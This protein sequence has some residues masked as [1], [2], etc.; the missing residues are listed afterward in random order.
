MTKAEAIIEQ[1]NRLPEPHRTQALNNHANF[2]MN[3]TIVENNA[4]AIVDPA[5]AIAWGFVL[6]KTPEGRDY[7]NK[8]KETFDY[9]Y[10]KDQDATQP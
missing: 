3:P 10:F 1:L 6:V 5:L 9:H 8:A 2:P 7:W 4:P